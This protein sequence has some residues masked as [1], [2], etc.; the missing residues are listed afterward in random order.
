[1]APSRQRSLCGGNG[2][3]GPGNLSKRVTISTSDRI[4]G[5]LSLRT[6]SRIRFNASLAPT[7]RFPFLTLTIRFLVSDPDNS[8]FHLRITIAPPTYRLR[9]ICASPTGIMR[10]LSCESHTHTH[11]LRITYASL[12]HH[13]RIARVSPTYNLRITCA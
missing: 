3:G 13:L 6:R 10:I 7:I 12:A 9:I 4:V 2:F 1:M 11:R 5:V 8:V